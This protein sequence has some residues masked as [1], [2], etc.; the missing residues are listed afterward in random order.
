MLEALGSS[1]KMD[2]PQSYLEVN[3]FVQVHI[4]VL[5]STGAVE[6]SST[7]VVEG[8]SVLTMPQAQGVLQLSIHIYAPRC[9]NGHMLEP[10][11]AGGLGRTGVLNP[12]RG[13]QGVHDRLCTKYDPS[14]LTAFG[15]FLEHDLRDLT[16]FGSACGFVGIKYEQFLSDAAQPA[17]PCADVRV[18]IQQRTT[19]CR[20][21]RTAF[22]GACLTVCWR[23]CFPPA[24]PLK[25]ARS[26]SFGGQPVSHGAG[27]LNI[28]STYVRGASSAILQLQ[29]PTC[30]GQP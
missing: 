22:D 10:K 15:S 8:A 3:A 11:T 14:Y 28:D 9:E 12:F 19:R 25:E 4:G 1:Q 30:C 17:L 6:A 29:L 2:S 16:A 20:A 18:F 13:S 7:L 21:Q 5:A 24:A 26:C 23:I 27:S